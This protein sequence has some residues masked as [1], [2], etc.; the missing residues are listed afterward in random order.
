M[1]TRSTTHFIYQDSNGRTYT[2]AIIYRHWDGYPEGA[3]T[4]IFRFLAQVKRHTFDTRFSDPSYL[5]A[6]Y[7]VWLSQEP[8]AH[9]R[10]RFPEDN[11]CLDFLS[12]GV[13]S[14]DPGDIKYRYTI[15]C[16]KIL[17]N[18][19][20]EV[21]GYRVGYCSDGPE[22]PGTRVAIPRP[23]ASEAA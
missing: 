6:K 17:K 16:G 18:G 22:N 8:F 4:D 1:G 9:D 11:R 3:G 2:E 20:P 7:V 10:G 15:N 21:K 5:A 19:L 23:K 13:C 12:V 14:E